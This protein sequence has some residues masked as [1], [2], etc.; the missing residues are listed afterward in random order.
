[1]KRCTSCQTPYPDEFAFCPLDGAE[2]DDP[3]VY[4][5]GTTIRNKYRI[6]AK[7]GKGGMGHVYKALHLLF[8]EVRALK[9]MDPG[10]TERED[11]VRRFHRE[12]F[13]ARRLQHPNAVR[14]D[15]V[16]ETEDGRHLIVMEYI[17]GRMLRDVLMREG[18]LPAARACSIVKQVASALDAAHQLG[19]IHR[20]IKPENIALVKGEQGDLVK[21]LDFGITKL[22]EGRLKEEA[23]SMALTATGTVFAIGTPEYMSPEQV[24]QKELD[25]RSDLYSLGLVFYEMLAGELP[26]HADSQAEWFLAQ[27]S[28]APRPLQD[29]PASLRTPRG[30]ANLVMSMLEKASASRPASGAA[31]IEAIEAC[32]KESAV[33]AAIAPPGGKAAGEKQRGEATT[34]PAYFEGWKKGSLI[35]QRYKILDKIAEVRMGPIY[36]ALDSGDGGVCA[37]KLVTPW[38]VPTADLINQL[39]EYFQRMQRFQNPHVVRIIELGQAEDGVL[40]LVT[41][42]VQGTSLR[43]IIEQQSSLG[44]TRSCRI[45]WEIAFALDAGQQLGILHGE[46][47]PEHILLAGAGKSEQT[48]I[49]DFSLDR[50]KEALPELSGCDLPAGLLAPI[51]YLPPE[52]ISGQPYLPASDIYSL[53]IVFYE[54]LTG[55]R[56]FE[57]TGIEIALRQ[58]QEAPLPVE[59]VRPELRIPPSVASLVMRMI[60][61]DPNDRPR[62]GRT[63]MEEISAV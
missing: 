22:R 31:V 58:V 1:M 49:L 17:D 50:V 54:M 5:V 30:I 7:V 3:T 61:K 44:V 34:V 32:E 24:L 63:L 27:V 36:T 29:Q 41:E 52:R 12:A 6:L 62:D 33:L 16:D 20:D 10:L 23:G 8:N 37:L 18:P 39:S 53:G 15:D 55:R 11:F 48:K 45:V 46:I 38:N 57:G 28:E 35:A 19:I 26:F 42:Y 43:H 2:L 60:Q 25:G 47:K 13:V 40:F 56:P 59:Q 4:A 21:V 9:V 14:V 51:H